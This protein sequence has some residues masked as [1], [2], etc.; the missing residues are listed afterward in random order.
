[1]IRFD[2]HSFWHQM[3]QMYEVT[4]FETCVTKIIPFLKKVDICHGKLAKKY[5]RI[6]K[7]ICTMF[8]TFQKS[9][10]REKN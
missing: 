10:I 2:M 6:Y 5:T 3:T 8:L 4:S 9:E 7:S 1:M